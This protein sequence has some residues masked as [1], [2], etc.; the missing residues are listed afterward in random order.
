MIEWNQMGT[1]DFVQRI[2]ADKWR[3][4]FDFRQLLRREIESFLAQAFE[5]ERIGLIEDELQTPK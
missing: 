2:I 5:F 3:Q 1:G 4:I